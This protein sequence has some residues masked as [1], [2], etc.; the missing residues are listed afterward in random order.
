MI[1]YM[2]GY[3]KVGLRELK[4]TGGKIESQQ[5]EAGVDKNSEREKEMSTSEF[6]VPL[7]S[8]CYDDVNSIHFLV[9]KECVVDYCT[10]TRTSI[11]TFILVFFFFATK[12]V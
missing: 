11:F 1:D 5:Q 2:Q 10:P 6:S 9:M 3:R 12:Y 8:P 7:L 4:K